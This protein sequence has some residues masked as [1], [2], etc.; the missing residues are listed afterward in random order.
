MSWR[1]ITEDWRL[2]LLA[3]GLAVLMLGA[4]AFSQNPPTSDSQKVQLG[5]NIPSSLILISPPNTVNV[6]YSGTADEIQQAKNCSCFTATVDVSHAKPGSNVKLN[7]VAKST[8]TALIV[9]NPPPINVT[10][11]T[12][13]QGKDLQV[14]VSAHAAPG[15]SITKTSASCPNSPC[16][17]HFSGP[18]GW[19]K[20]MAATVTYPG[21]VNLSS[22]D[23]PNQTIQLSNINGQVDLT[24]CRTE[25]CASLDT[26]AA[27][28]H[29]EAVP[30]SNSSTIVLLDSPPS[31]PP[32]NGYRVTAV[33]ITPLT[34]TIT[35]DPTT[36]GRYRSITLPAIDLTGKTADYTTQVAIPYPDGVTGSVANATIKYSISPN[37]A[38]SPSSTP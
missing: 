13:V 37:P 3:A 20:N 10:I 24:T 34:V 2:K 29:I 38:V 15:W 36:I 1:I 8:I 26:L 9:Q 23:S 12:Y 28:I 4:V 16:V 11:D 35:G 32:A 22:I 25:P 31:H 27:S 17:V 7:V 6:T 18:A 33:T 30:G 14:Q 19:L 5:Y 21:A